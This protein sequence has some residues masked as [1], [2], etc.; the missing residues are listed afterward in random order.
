MR[1]KITITISVLLLLLAVY[2]IARDLFRKP[3]ELTNASYCIDDISVL[4]QIDTALVGYSRVATISTGVN[5]LTGIA[6]NEENRVFACGN[7]RVVIFDSTGKTYGGFPV[8]TIP[9][10]IAL[11]GPDIYLGLG[12][13]IACFS[14]NGKKISQWKPVGTDGYITS[15]AFNEGY[16]YAADAVR[17]IILKYSPDCKLIHEIGKRDT[18]TGAIGFV[19]PSMY[20]DI[21]FGAFSDLWAVNPGRLRIENYTTDG[22]YQSGWGTA[23]SENSGFTGCCNPAHFSKLPDGGFVTYEKGVDKIKVFDPTGG[24]ICFVAGADSFKGDTDFQLNGNLVK[25]MAVGNDGL[26]YILDAYSQIN[27]FRKKD[28]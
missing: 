27:I 21:S 13:G 23:A 18:L 25:D 24:F 9:S 10:C 2:L 5:D 26:I 15:V 28:L 22:H 7:R 20:F 19:I 14:S 11:N 16:V 1:Q 6:V 4:K 17:K 8:D 3:A 12:S